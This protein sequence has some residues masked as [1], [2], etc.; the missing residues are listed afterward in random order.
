MLNKLERKLG[1]YAIKNL[2]IWLICAYVV[3][4]LLQIMG[5]NDRVAS[6]IDYL[7][8]NPYLILHGQIWRIITWV[9]IPPGDLGIFTVIMLFF[10]FSLGTSLE[11]TWGT[12]RYN[13]YIFGGMIITVLGSFIIAGIYAV[14]GDYNSMY[15]V[16]YYFSTYYINMSIF[17]AYAWSF[18]DMQVLL[19]FIIPIKIKWIAYIDIVMLA[20][21]FF[22]SNWSNRV[23]I[24][25]SLANFF[26]FFFMTRDYRKMSPSE[27]RRK[28]RFKKQIR[29]AAMS[30][31]HRCTICGRTEQDGDDLVFRYCSKCEGNYEYCQDHLYN[32]LHVKR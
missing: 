17:L 22:I 13:V 10:Y 30:G 26:V 25:C 8:L 27:I 5:E 3:G 14:M 16:G 2:S 1:K 21:D 15:M 23:T 11:H 7:Y 12:F 32:H 28:K 6:L 18:P 31:K 20:Y 24:L 9:F 4:Y 19:Y 29:P